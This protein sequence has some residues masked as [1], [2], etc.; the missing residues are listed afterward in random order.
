MMSI[1]PQDGHPTLGK[2]APSIQ[3]AGHSPAVPLTLM[4][5]SMCPY[6]NANDVDVFNRDDVYWHGPLGQAEPGVTS[7]RASI[8]RLPAPS[9][10]ALRLLV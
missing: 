8:T 1:S 10:D 4:R 3:R 2:L 5:A 7:L 6:V 9:V